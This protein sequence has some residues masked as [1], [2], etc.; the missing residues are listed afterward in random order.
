MMASVRE[1]E[2]VRSIALLTSMSFFVS[3]RESFSV[4]TVSLFKDYHL[5]Q[6]N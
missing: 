6:Q 4:P 3:E 5:F 2:I 1:I